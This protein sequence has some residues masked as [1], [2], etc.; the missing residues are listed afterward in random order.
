MTAHDIIKRP[1]LSEKSL[2]AVNEKKYV[3][4]VDIRATKTEIR[5]AVEQL[6]DGTKVHSVHT[7]RVSGKFKRQG[8]SSGYT[9]DYKKAIVQL[10]INSK[11]IPFFDSLN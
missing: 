8:K 2:S 9:S 11:N 10:S 3:F 1:I 4:E 7:V 5:A 6:F